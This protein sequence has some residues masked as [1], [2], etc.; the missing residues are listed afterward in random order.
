VW[1]PRNRLV[2]QIDEELVQAKASQAFWQAETLLLA[3]TPF[4]SFAQRQVAL[5]EAEIK[6]LLEAHEALIGVPDA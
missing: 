5:R 6:Q 1:V 3:A 4:L 2:A